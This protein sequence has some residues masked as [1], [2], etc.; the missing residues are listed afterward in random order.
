MT[1]V[2]AHVNPVAVVMLSDIRISA[3]VGST[4]K[5]VTDFGVKKIHHVAWT[6]FAGF[7]GSIPLG[8]A[9]VDDLYRHLQDA[10]DPHV[11]TSTLASD[12]ARTRLPRLSQM[13]QPA[14]DRPTQV[15]A[16]W[17]APRSYRQV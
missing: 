12:W 17:H 8:F 13:E 11:P 10:Y 7:A 16:G 6:A 15:I 9:L 14:R 2:I 4:T 3:R 1:W 5:E